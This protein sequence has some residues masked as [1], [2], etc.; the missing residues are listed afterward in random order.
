[1]G[2]APLHACTLLTHEPATLLTQLTRL[3][4]TYGGRGHT[5]LFALSAN[6]PR[7]DDLQAVVHRLTTFHHPQIPASAN[8]AT[9]TPRGHGHGHTVG[10]LTDVPQ[11]EAQLS[12]AVAV[13][14]SA[15]C[16]PFRSALAGRVQ[17]QV[18]RWHAFRKQSESEGELPVS[19][20]GAPDWGDDAG[21]GAPV[22]WEAVWS[23]S[24]QP[25]AAALLPEALE[26]I[27]QVSLPC[28]SF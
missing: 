17:P 4:A 24:S 11:G 19:A 3:A 10:C 26:S 23:R 9:T 18:G 8:T 22:D 13:F 14:D 2:P 6:F 5:L 28:I 25:S 20:T 21:S 27:P 16:V 15:H 1:M 7:A 12:C